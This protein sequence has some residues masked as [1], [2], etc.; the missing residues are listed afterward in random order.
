MPS[1]VRIVMAGKDVS[2]KDRGQLKVRVW[3][4]EGRVAKAWASSAS[5]AVTISSFARLVL[6]SHTSTDLLFFLLNSISACRAHISDSQDYSRNTLLSTRLKVATRWPVKPISLASWP[7]WVRLAKPSTRQVPMSNKPRSSASCFQSW[8]V[9]A[10]RPSPRWHASRLPSEPRTRSD[11]YPLT[12]RLPS[13][14]AF[15]LWQRRPQRHPPR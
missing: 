15:Q 2:G 12:W 3:R 8:P 11:S 6:L 10:A 7:L 14:A 5:C 13:T 1:R 4:G 9:P